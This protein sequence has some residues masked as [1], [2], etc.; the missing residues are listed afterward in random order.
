M[1]KQSNRTKTC[2][3]FHNVE[4]SKMKTVIDEVTEV[5]IKHDLET[6]ELIIVME[7]LNKSMH[8]VLDHFGI[9]YTVT[10]V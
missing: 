10:E 6:P 3:S 2:C 1:R 4:N 5:F 9:K 8:H 7:H